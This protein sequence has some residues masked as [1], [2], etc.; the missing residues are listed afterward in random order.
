M[1]VGSIETN[2]TEVRLRILERLRKALLTYPQNKQARPQ[3]NVCMQIWPNK[4]GRR[5][6]GGETKSLDD[7]LLKSL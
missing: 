2:T 6:G 7:Y 5:R 4:L 1:H 3:K